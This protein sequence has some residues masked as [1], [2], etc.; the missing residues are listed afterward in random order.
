MCDKHLHGQNWKSIEINR[1]QA[2]ETG[3][4]HFGAQPVKHRAAQGVLSVCYSF[5]VGR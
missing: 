4:M 5:D 2:F 3:T 1:A